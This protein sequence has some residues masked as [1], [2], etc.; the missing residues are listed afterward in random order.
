VVGDG[1]E[2]GGGFARVAVSRGFDGLASPA[3]GLADLCKLVLDFYHYRET[4]VT[5]EGLTIL[6]IGT[7]P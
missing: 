2:P 7:D 3:G 6:Y 1:L 5:K 4:R